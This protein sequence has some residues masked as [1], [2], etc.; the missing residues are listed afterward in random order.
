MSKLVNR[1]QLEH[2]CFLCVILTSQ[3]HRKCR[4]PR[5]IAGVSTHDGSHQKVPHLAF[6]NHYVL[7]QELQQILS[8]MLWN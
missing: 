8:Q 1:K 6:I 4:L 2:A 7:Q 3:L 5:D